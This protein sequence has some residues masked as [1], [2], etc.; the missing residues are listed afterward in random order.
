MGP[1]DISEEVLRQVGFSA[2]DQAK[3]LIRGLAGQG[4]TDDDLSALLPMLL[5]S[6]GNSPDPDRSLA[7]FARWLGAVGSPYAHLQLLHRH[8]VALE[9]FCVVTGSS[10]LFADLL[11]RQPETF[12]IIA[13]PGVRGG[14]KSY[15]QFHREVSELVQAC[16]HPELKRDVL[17][18]WKAREMFRIGVRDL[19][20]LAD[21]PATAHE[22]SNLAD[23]CVQTAFEIAR[24]TLHPVQ[25]PPFAVIAMGK[26]GGQELNYSS[27]IDLMFVHADTL[28]D[29]IDL[30]D[31]RRMETMLYLSRFAE[32]LTKALAE[33]TSQGHVFRVDLRLRPEG[34]FGPITRSLESFRVYYEQWGE[35]WERQALLK[36]RFIAG[37]RT[38]GEAYQRMI[39]PYVYRP[40]VSPSLT[41]AIRANKRRIEQKCAIEHETETNI[42]TGF[43]GIRDIE[44]IVQ[45]LQLAFGGIKPRLQTPNTLIA[46]KRLHNAGLLTSEE[47]HQLS[48]DYQFLRNLEHR[49]QLLHGMQTQT[50]PSAD[51][52]RERFRLARRMGLPDAAAL[53]AEL[54]T[55]RARVHQALQSLFYLSEEENRFSHSIDA[56]ETWLDLEELLDNLDSPTVVETLSIRLRAAGFIDVPLALRALRLPMQGNEFGGMP[57]DTPVEFRT[58]ASR[59]LLLA[60]Q[61]PDPDAALAGFEALALA[62]PNRAQLYAACDDSP[63]ML[64]RLVRLGGASP[65]LMKLLARHQEWLETLISPEEEPDDTAAAISSDLNR[66][67][68]EAGSYE[69]KLDAIARFQQRER[70]RIGA[71][72]AWQESDVEEVM[73]HLAELAAAVVDA[74]LHLCGEAQSM[75]SPDPEAT[76]AALNR[77][78]VIG[79][80]KLG[81]AEPG[82]ASDWDLL[83]L[84]REDPLQ[85]AR[86][87]FDAAQGL[88][89]RILAAGKA[90]EPRGG[91]VDLDLRLR[92]WGNKGAL[93]QT[94]GQLIHYHR[95]DSEMWE[96]QAALKAR[97]I[98]GHPAVGRRAITILRAVSYGRGLTP[99]SNQAVQ[100]MKRRV[101]QERLEPE[102][103]HSDLKLGYGGLTDIEWL[104]Q[105]LQ[106]RYGKPLPKLRTPNT[107]R[108]LDALVS[109][110][111]LSVPE[112]DL[113]IS[114]YRLLTRARN[115]L[116]LQSGMP[117]DILPA[118][119]H[120]CKTLA[121][122]LSRGD[123]TPLEDER[124]SPEIQSRMIE[125]RQL[126]ERLFYHSS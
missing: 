40:I 7:S 101:E 72:D 118:D 23:A 5:T 2:I 31:G 91:S 121:R 10:Q 12:E 107:L 122:M 24:D 15:F 17:R 109:A 93:A 6:L 60:S 97:F 86:A 88:V 75:A 51:N 124:L 48:E 87:Q 49:L 100:S 35:A 4:I 46:L 22:F 105:K 68:R 116:W 74:L 33:E 21:M 89:E 64:E 29:H 102:K 67:L 44:F 41:E 55:R 45:R 20:G 117:Q 71:K 90:L 25:L 85:D 9:L 111:V 8:S 54:A 69:A 73:G 123:D 57:P 104:V 30:A 52:L 112:A 39:T 53:T 98:A 59:L 66:R 43:G 82:Y 65:P 32:A 14:V 78:A 125:V 76:R 19:A 83:F 36:A 103:R 28:P 38:L 11:V 108:A 70:L 13:N 62:V 77:L 84:Y 120:R 81:G 126:F 58:I 47:A 94:L 63:Q 18:R 61:A 16:R 95:T 80:G 119:P 113:L 1:H 115:A 92:P 42:K 37:D 56:T 50:L 110:H 34:R 106:L 99:E 3:A 79:L 96:R 114:T 27:D 26:L